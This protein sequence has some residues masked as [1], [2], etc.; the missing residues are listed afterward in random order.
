M[1]PGLWQAIIDMEKASLRYTFTFYKFTDKRIGDT[2]HGYEKDGKHG[3]VIC[4]NCQKVL[5]VK[6]EQTKCTCGVQVTITKI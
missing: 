1:S 6:G 4:P 3:I 5:E 2:Y